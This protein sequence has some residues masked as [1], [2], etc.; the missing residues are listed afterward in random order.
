MAATPV[1]KVNG[2]LFV[3]TRCKLNKTLFQKVCKSKHHQTLTSCFP[4]DASWDVQGHGPTGTGFGW[5][6]RTLLKTAKDTLVQESGP[7]HYATLWLQGRWAHPARTYARLSQH[8]LRKD[9]REWR[10]LSSSALECTNHT[11]KISF[12]LKVKGKFIENWLYQVKLHVK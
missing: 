12:F 4:F 10:C 9:T 8:A 6:R 2:S 5:A 3:K 7:G 1:D 11:P